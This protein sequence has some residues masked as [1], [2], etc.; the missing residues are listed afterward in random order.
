MTALILTKF[1]KI[2]SVGMYY[3]FMGPP[4]PYINVEVLLNIMIDNMM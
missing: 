1:Q 2:S 4:P 3:V